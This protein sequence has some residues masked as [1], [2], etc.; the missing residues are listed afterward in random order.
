MVGLTPRGALQ[1]TSR[2]A[3]FEKLVSELPLSDFLL[4]CF[5][6]VIETALGAEI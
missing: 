1:E 2:T 6:I 3:L 5:A 4:F